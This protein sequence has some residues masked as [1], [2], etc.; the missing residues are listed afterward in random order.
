MPVSRFRN[1]LL[2]DGGACNPSGI[3]HSFIEACQEVQSE[4]GNTR[5]DPAC[6][7]IVHQLASLYGIELLDR[8]MFNRW[9]AAVVACKKA[10]DAEEVSNSST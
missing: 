7:L 4:G 10:V 6:F 2:I 9:E 8:E 5:T 3:A 1:A